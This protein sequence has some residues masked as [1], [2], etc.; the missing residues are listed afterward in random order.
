[1]RAFAKRAGVS[2]A[3]MSL[4]IQGKRT[5]SQKLAK[6]LSDRLDFDPQE[7]SEILA[8]TLD[9]KA[10]Q[11]SAEDHEA[12]V[13]I[14]ID[15]YRLIS[16]WRAFAILSLIKTLDFQSSNEWIANRLG[17]SVDEVIET[18]ER[19]KRLGMLEEK[20]GR[21]VRT[22]S[23]YRTTEDIANASLRKSHAQTLDL[24]QAS[25]ERDPVDVRDFTWLTIPMD[26]EK[27]ALA[28]TMIRKFQDD[29]STALETDS[30]PSE[31]YRLAIQL[32]PLT[33]IKKTKGSKK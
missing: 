9:T 5:V 26:M 30:N 16:D 23:K 31:V 2:V 20:Q 1:M 8:P 33:K 29:L 18:I 17:I 19:L 6:E 28:K 27:L 12:Y 4:I 25:L 13:Q 32:F 14:S 11:R 21:Y 3:T 24:A 22:V 15:Q 7:R 10:G